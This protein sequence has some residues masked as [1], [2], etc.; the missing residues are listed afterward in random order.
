MTRAWKHNKKDR[1]QWGTAKENKRLT[2]FMLD[3]ADLET[4]ESEMCYHNCDDGI[5]ETEE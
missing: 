3:D 1:H 5:S 2:P 4:W